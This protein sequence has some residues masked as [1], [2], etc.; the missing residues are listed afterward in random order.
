MA[1]NALTVVRVTVELEVDKK[2]VTHTASARTARFMD[3]P[4][5][6]A[7]VRVP[8]DEEG[9]NNA[10]PALTRNPC[11]MPYSHLANAAMATPRHNRAVE[12]G[13]TVPVVDAGAINL[14][15]AVRDRRVD[16]FDDLS[17]SSNF[18]AKASAPRP[19]PS[20]SDISSASFPIAT[21]MHSKWPGSGTRTPDDQGGERLGAARA[22][23]DGDRSKGGGLAAG[24]GDAAA[25][26]DVAW[27]M[28]LTSATDT[29]ADAGL[30]S[31]AGE[32]K[33]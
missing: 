16:A 5:C 26:A 10:T 4:S 20:D 24:A 12:Y 27:H 32:D 2:S 13:V 30:P 9:Q 25:I 21:W 28:Q 1:H 23:A 14:P 6:H 11:V 17:G 15:G 33:Q 3:S 7:D 8:I 22:G 18:T 31:C 29:R 19:A